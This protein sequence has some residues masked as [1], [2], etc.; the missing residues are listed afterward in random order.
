MGR[1]LVVE[2]GG[3]GR[4]ASKGDVVWLLGHH[5]GG[6]VHAGKLG[7]GETGEMGIGWGGRGRESLSVL[8]VLLEHEIASKLLV[9]Y[10]LL[11]LL[12]L[13]LLV[14]LLLVALCGGEVG[15]GGREEGGVASTGEKRHAVLLLRGRL[16]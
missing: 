10:L 12:L 7:M 13:L 5:S 14:H 1:C 6:E 9:R 8:G 15:L 4:Y 3:L 11:L 16:L 2:R